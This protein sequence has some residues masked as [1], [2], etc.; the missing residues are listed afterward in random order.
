MKQIKLPVQLRD[1]I[2]RAPTRRLRETGLIPAVVYGK[3]GV[4]HLTVREPDFRSCRA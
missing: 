4:R 1:K 2:G 3:S